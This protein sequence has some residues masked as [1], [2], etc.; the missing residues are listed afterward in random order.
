MLNLDIKHKSPRGE[1]L[2]QDMKNIITKG[3][4]N[5]RFLKKWV[6]RNQ[7][8]QGKQAKKFR[9]KFI[10]IFSKISEINNGLKINSDKKILDLYKRNKKLWVGAYD[11]IRLLPEVYTLIDQDFLNKIEKSAGIKIP[12]LLQTSCRVYAKKYRNNENSSSHRLS[13][14]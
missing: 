11:Q 9:I 12:H 6:F 4:K 7:N 5:E 8:T 2:D 14:T 3:L 13:I 1:A 10:K